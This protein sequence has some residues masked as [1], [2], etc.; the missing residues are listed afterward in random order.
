M[1]QKTTPF[2]LVYESFFNK[3]YDDMFL[4]LTPEDTKKIQEKLLMS[5][6]EYFEFP[7]KDIYSFGTSEDGSKYFINELTREEVNIIA[8]YMVVE[9]I[10]QQLATID[11]IRMKYSGSDFKL[12][13]Q[14]SH[15]DKL[16]K[17]KIDFQEDAFHLQRLYKR[18]H[19]DKD[20]K[21]KTTFNMLMGEDAP[22]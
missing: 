12:T 18:R 5:A 21:F 13:S 8:S 14:A 6:L 9:W 1:E 15:I 16:Q 11:L 3:I 19:Q 22:W 7:K 2:S 17:L 4:E 20:G 10:K